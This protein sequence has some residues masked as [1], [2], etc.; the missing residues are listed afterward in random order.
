MIAVL[1]IIALAIFEMLLGPP[2]PSSFV[3]SKYAPFF[4]LIDQVV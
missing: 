2:L 3:K 1:F 4:P